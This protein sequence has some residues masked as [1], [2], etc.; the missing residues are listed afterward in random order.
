MSCRGPFGEY[1]RFCC[2]VRNEGLLSK[3]NIPVGMTLIRS[4]PCG[5]SFACYN[6]R[7]KYI[8]ENQVC[9]LML[10]I[11][12][13]TGFI[14]AQKT[15][16]TLVFIISYDVFNQDHGPEKKWIIVY[17][18][19]GNSDYVFTLFWGLLLMRLAQGVRSPPNFQHARSF[20]LPMHTVPCRQIV[21]HCEISSCAIR[22]EVFRQAK[23]D[24]R[25]WRERWLQLWLS[26]LRG[27]RCR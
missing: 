16:L 18:K 19:T 25:G 13:Y 10:L 26:K 14:E 5:G 6:S 9:K 3:P 27:C 4:G 11:N 21:W 12:N 20:L 7:I 2:C 17:N 1:F 15:G 24:R 8:T 22:S 23:C